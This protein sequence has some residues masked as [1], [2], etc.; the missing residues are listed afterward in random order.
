MDELIYLAENIMAEQIYDVSPFCKV[1]AIDLL[2]E[3][4]ARYGLLHCGYHFDEIAGGLFIA[5]YFPETSLIKDIKIKIP[6]TLGERSW[7]AY[8]QQ[9]G[10]VVQVNNPSLETIL[11]II[12]TVHDLV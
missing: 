9:N 7:I 3:I 1:E 8:T 10:Q 5:W 12:G 11:K 6:N 2:T 4:N